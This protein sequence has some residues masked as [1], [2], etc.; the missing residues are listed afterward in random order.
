MEIFSE[1]LISPRE[2][3]FIIL[4]GLE[5]GYFL[6]YNIFYEIFHR[7]LWMSPRIRAELGTG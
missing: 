1:N 5:R 6:F 3:I 2:E 7:H 4:K